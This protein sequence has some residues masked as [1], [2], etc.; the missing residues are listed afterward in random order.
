MGV[1]HV[2]RGA[3]PGA[4]FGKSAF[5]E[6]APCLHLALCRRDIA[7]CCGHTIPG[8]DDRF[9]HDPSR[10]LDAEPVDAVLI[11][12][13]RHTR[14]HSA[15]RKQR[16]GEDCLPIKGLVLVAQVIRRSLPGQGRVAAQHQR[17]AP[18]GARGFDLCARL[19]LGRQRGRQIGVVGFGQVECFANGGRNAGQWRRFGQYAG[20]APDQRGKCRAV[21]FEL[22]HRAVSRRFGRGQLGFG[23]TDVGARQF[24]SN[25]ARLDLIARRF[26]LALVGG[27]EPHRLR[28]APDV[29]IGRQHVE[30][31]RALGSAQR[32]APG[33]HFGQRRF[34][35]GVCFAA[36]QQRLIDRGGGGLRVAGD[37][38]RSGQEPVGL[39]GPAGH[40]LG[41]VA[42]YGDIGIGARFGQCQ[43]IILVGHAHTIALLL[44][45]GRAAPCGIDSVGQRFGRGRF[46]IEYKCRHRP[47][48]G[49]GGGGGTF[50]YAQPRAFDRDRVSRGRTRWPGQQQRRTKARQDQAQRCHC[51]TNTPSGA[52]PRVSARSCNATMPFSRT[53]L[54]RAP[55]QGSMATNV[56]LSRRSNGIHT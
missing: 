23:Q 30:Q 15:T 1:E 39:R 35:I 19:A 52:Q 2:E 29:G 46:R 53:T 11:F 42:G 7:L 12:D 18:G 26:H 27:I 21:L 25:L 22:Q 44:H 31:Q 3:Q 33:T 20:I 43:R 40:G 8:V 5:V 41:I 36:G 28:I 14:M 55:G 50:L 47:P 13:L 51:S 9:D 16:D 4:I 54:G 49:G 48:G 37:N 45:A 38:R 6:N 17:R 10:R 32:F 24:A 56:A 34:A